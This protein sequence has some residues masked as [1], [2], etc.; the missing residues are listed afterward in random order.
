MSINK[1][2][3][4][5]KT[6]GVLFLML[7]AFT[8]AEAQTTTSSP[9]SRYGIGDF[10][11]RGLSQN[12]G[13][14]GIS[15]G[16]EGANNLN[17]GNP[18]SYSSLQFTSFDAGVASN[19]VKYSD[20]I[21]SQRTSTTSLS[22]LAFGFPVSKKWGT[23][24]GLTPY[25][26]VGYNINPAPEMGPNGENI[27]YS[28]KGS[29]GLSQFYVGTAYKITK[30]L[31]LGINVAYLFGSILREQTIEFPDTSYSYN[32]HVKNTIS[33]GDVN[34]T[35]G[36]QYNKQL[37]NDYKLIIG[38]TGSFTNNIH[39]T[40]TILEERYTYR[41]GLQYPKDS[42]PETG[43]VKGSLKLPA[44]IGVGI[45][46]KNNKVMAGVD[47]SMQNWSKYEAFGAT[48]NLKNSY[49]VAGGLEYI[50]GTSTSREYI[51]AIKYRA[52]LHFSQ[53][54]LELRGT[55]LNE[56]GVTVGLGLPIP[57]SLSVASVS[58]EYGLRGTTDNQLI[59]E[60]Y[61]RINIG[62]SFNDTWFIKRKY[63]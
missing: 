37:K 48:E 20:G 62:F 57:K 2:Y 16:L 34:L 7:G 38:V 36:L 13:M 50:P 21:Q 26:S 1:I 17:P 53:T 3:K 44:K 23:S 40:N 55:Q 15:Y 43:I 22:Y 5:A 33:V 52:G 28:Y 29:G 24:F 46:I 63:D 41:G 31:S 11:F 49:F 47:F 6:I 27:K 4:I 60:N 14:G 59:R 42:L 18:A 58:F 8:L 30:S 51:K 12:I 56:T 19:I 35:Y 10:Q 61:M 32:T 39:A 45:A 54:Y 25:S 9:Y